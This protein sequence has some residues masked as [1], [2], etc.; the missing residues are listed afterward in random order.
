MNMQNSSLDK[1]LLLQFKSG[2]REQQRELLE[3]IENV[4]REMREFAGPAPSDA[5]DLSCVAASKES[6]LARASQDHIR[7]RLIQ[8][9]LE[10][11]KDG[12]FGICAECEGPIGL[13]RLQVVP[14]A[15]NCIACQQQ[16]EAAT[17]AGNAPGYLL[18]NSV[19]L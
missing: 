8:Q 14:C 16:A 1:Y 2:L 19:C 15:R 9:A 3:T 5:I 10:R 12:T 7:L 17:L 4:E 6:L 18:S 11:I 13:K